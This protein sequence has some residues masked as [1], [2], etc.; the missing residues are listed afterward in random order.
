MPG[1]TYMALQMSVFSNTVLAY[2]TAGTVYNWD[3]PVL[4]PILSSNITHFPTVENEP[5]ASI[6]YPEPFD[7]VVINLRCTT[8]HQPDVDP[9][10]CILYDDESYDPYPRPL[11]LYTIKQLGHRDHPFL[12]NS[13]LA[14][15]GLCAHVFGDHSELFYGAMSSL[16]RSEDC[17]TFCANSNDDGILVTVL[18]VPEKATLGALIPVTRK[19]TPPDVLHEEFN[20]V[21]LGYCPTSGRLIY[22]ARD[23]S[24]YLLDFLSSPEE[25]GRLM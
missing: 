8:A 18:P 19:L 12:P 1:C 21:Q 3:I 5:K 14:P 7:N 10:L 16:Y 6:S 25:R 4:Q 24:F 23:G 11:A 22:R 17:V 13:L 2:D 15:A 20:G 9:V